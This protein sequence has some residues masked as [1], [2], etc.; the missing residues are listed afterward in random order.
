MFTR[1]Y[2]P[3]H[4][5]TC[6]QTHISG[7]ETPLCPVAAV[8]PVLVHGCH[9]HAERWAVRGQDSGF[10][11]LVDSDTGHTFHAVILGCV[12][13]LVGCNLQGV[14]CTVR[15]AGHTPLVVILTESCVLVLAGHTPLVDGNAPQLGHTLP[16]AGCMAMLAGYIPPVAVRT[17]LAVGYKALTATSA[18]FEPTEESSVAHA[19]TV[20]PV[21]ELVALKE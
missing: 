8:H 20:W 2:T 15:D 12:L 11:D 1:T 7:C 13:L 16:N 5:H 21:L 4:I 6:S 19:C 18:A 14:G 17:P 3:V 9:V 10:E